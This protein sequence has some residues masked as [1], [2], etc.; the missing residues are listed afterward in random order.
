M[1]ITAY[2]LMTTG[3]I[4]SQAKPRNISEKFSLQEHALINSIH[5]AYDSPNVGGEPHGRYEAFQLSTT[6]TC[7]VPIAKRLFAATSS[8]FPGGEQTI[9]VS[10]TTALFVY[11]QKILNIAWNRTLEQFPNWLD[12][13]WVYDDHISRKTRFTSPLRREA[14]EFCRD[15]I[16]SLI[17]DTSCDVYESMSFH[18]SDGLLGQLDLVCNVE[19]LG[20]DEIVALQSRIAAPGGCVPDSSPLRFTADQVWQHIVEIDDRIMGLLNGPEATPLQSELDQQFFRAI[21]RKDFQKAESLLSKGADINSIDVF[22]YTALTTIL[23]EKMGKA[24]FHRLAF[25][26]S[27]GADPNLFGF[28]GD[29]PLYVAVHQ[30]PEFIQALLE[31]GADPNIN[32]SPAEEPDI[33]SSAL[34]HAYMDLLACPEFEAQFNEVI[35]LLE[36]AGA[37]YYINGI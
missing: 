6:G 25:L 24:A 17:N 3:T 21:K 2:L 12:H 18:Q 9:K 4:M 16:L 27:H 22:G 30:G 14:A 33:I 1:K 34:D 29:L 23:N 10:A 26:L 15:T 37:I 8:Q 19:K 7:P 13:E 35:R 28:D 36:E 31:H 11:C 20:D 32:Q 5:E